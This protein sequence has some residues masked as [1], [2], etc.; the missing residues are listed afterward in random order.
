[1]N[2]D[3]SDPLMHQLNNFVMTVEL[4]RPLDDEFIRMWNK[5]Q[6]DLASFA[7][8]MQKQMSE[9]T[10]NYL[11]NDPQFAEAPRNQSWLKNFNWQANMTQASKS[12]DSQ[13]QYP[14][15]VSHEMLSMASSFQ[16]Q[17]VD[18]LNVN[19]VQKVLA[20]AADL[21][22]YLPMQVASRTPY[23]PGGPREQLG[24]LMSH[25]G[26]LRSS[27]YRFLPLFVSKVHD[28][29][30]RLN[31]PKLLNTP[32]SA[33]NACASV[34]I[35]DGFGNA[36]MAQPCLRHEEYDNK[37]MVPHEFKAESGSPNGS[38]PSSGEVNSAYHS[39]PPMLSPG[40]EFSH[41]LPGADFN[42]MSEMVMSPMGPGPNSALNTPG[43]MNP[44]QGQ[45]QQHSPMSGMPGMAP[46]MPMN[47]TVPSMGHP[48]NTL[49]NQGFNMGQTL[50]SN[51]MMHRPQGPQRSNSFAMAQPRITVGDFQAL[52]R[53]NTDLGA[54]GAMNMSNMGPDMNFNGL[55]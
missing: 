48:M 33:T 54:I 17:G 11:S 20:V 15:D 44:Q 10:Q 8:T 2:D 26:M 46:G 45:H 36:G 29:V 23:G 27:D 35:F 22:D 25:L 47:S 1:M 9:A 30:S 7:T 28:I 40:L 38:V 51:G 37:F 52:Q 32:E 34:D 13:F 50:P 39:S 19:L 43:G 18:C 53:A 5:T 55:R 6:G 4:F 3:P 24:P 16:V 42:P 12:S 49:M 41:G 14:V 21:T 31:E